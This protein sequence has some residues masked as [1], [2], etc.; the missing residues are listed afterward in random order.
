MKNS[1]Q[2]WTELLLWQNFNL[3]NKITAANKTLLILFSLIL[4]GSAP[5]YSAEEYAHD[6][7]QGTEKK[8]I[9]ITRTDI[10]LKEKLATTALLYAGQWGYY[11][12]SQRK[13]IAQE[14]SFKNWYNNMYKVHLDKD[15][16]DYNIILHTL[17]G[18]YYYLY[19]R[20]RGYS[21]PITLLWSTIS[22][23]LF[24]FT[25]ETTTE[26]PSWQDI[27]Q[28]PVLGFVL[29][30]GF[31]SLSTF[32][33]NIDNPVASFFGYLLNPFA[34]FPFS[35]YEINAVPLLGTNYA[36]YGLLIRF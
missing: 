34:V 6:D 33:L 28:T 5:L 10:S 20:S 23:L 15:S 24:E 16:Y 12:A 18:N 3:K 31:E 14:G 19:Y 11:A 7:Y 1:F 2:T 25:I 4:I 27:Y 36:G 32:L 13:T 35:Y 21:K 17:A 26:R 9:H 8:F 30:V 29:G 22:V